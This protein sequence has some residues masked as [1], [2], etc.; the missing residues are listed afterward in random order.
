MPRINLSVT[1]SRNITGYIEWNEGNI[2]VAN[3]TSEVSASLVYVAPAG[4]IG[5]SGWD[6]SNF[7]L[8]INGTTFTYNGRAYI[9]DGETLTIPFTQET[10]VTV[11]HDADGS[12]SI[13]I[14]GG[15]Y[16]GTGNVG[17]ISASSG[18]ATVN[19][20]TIARPS[21]FGILHGSTIGSEIQIDIYR[22][23]PDFRHTI[24]WAFGSASGTISA[25]EVQTSD[26]ISYIKYTPP[27]PT[28]APQ[29][30]N[31]ISGDVT[32]TLTTY[33]DSSKT[34]QVGTP[35]TLN[36]TLTLPESVVPSADRFLSGDTNTDND[37][38]VLIQNVSEM[39]FS[40]RV[41]GA[42]GST[43]TRVDF[44]SDGITLGGTISNNI[45]TSEIF[46]PIRSDADIRPSVTVTDSRGRI[47]TLMPGAIDVYAYE[48]PRLYL[49]S[50]ERDGTTPAN[51]IATL[52]A[53]C[54]H[55]LI[56]STERNTMAC[57]ALYAPRTDDLP[58]P[59]VNYQITTSGLSA[60]NASRTFSLNARVSYHFQLQVTDHFFTSYMDI[61]VPT[62]S[63]ILDIRKEGYLGIGKYRERG[64]LDVNGSIF[65]SLN[66]WIGGKTNATDGLM[67]AALQ[68][69]G[70]VLLQGDSTHAPAINFYGS[71]GSTSPTASIE[72]ST[73]GVLTISNL[74]PTVL[75]I[76]ATETNPSSITSYF[77]LWVSNAT[78]GE[79]KTNDG[80]LYR[81][82]QGTANAQG[83]AILILGNG[84][85][86]GTA[87][88]KRG[89]TR[90]YSAGAYYADLVTETLTGNVTLQLP[91]KSGV[92]ATLDD[93]GGNYQNADN[94]SF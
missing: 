19:L 57:Y 79:A 2:N 48:P 84:T 12:K 60:S 24:A 40:A 88:N 87:G 43:I 36:Y 10:K 3:N 71:S 16:M 26:E 74:D 6:S 70:R 53:E 17:A 37:L 67:G 7:Y 23:S 94:I 52:S 65:G 11:Q 55:L 42:Y 13:T 45:A 28:Y 54:S 27:T 31:S 46:P 77:P 25:T 76:P 35:V 5:R 51:I 73:D 68:N 92:L 56:E 21:E 85:P 86:Q 49:G 15:G 4:S 50:A 80:I 47:F 78:G 69:Y 58:D 61:I 66:I 20:Q 33:T 41:S 1:S 22:K 91:N 59:G 34:T 81:T 29:I 9:S 63:V 38:G 75:D 62:D 18:S 89:R 64:A 39:Q 8:T 82:N 93:I 83:S 90:M 32:L 14:S 30:P 72:E 44:T